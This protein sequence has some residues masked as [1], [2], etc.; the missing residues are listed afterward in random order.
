VQEFALTEL[1]SYTSIIKNNT[2]I[3]DGGG[4]WNQA[5]LD[6]VNSTITYNK[7]KIG[8]GISNYGLINLDVET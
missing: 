2:A 3:E 5:V 8:G 6:L 1:C 7:A 4:I